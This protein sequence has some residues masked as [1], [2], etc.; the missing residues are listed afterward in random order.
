M[1]DKRTPDPRTGLSPGMTKPGMDKPGSKPDVQPTGMTGTS[2]LA[3]GNGAAAG[4]DQVSIRSRDEVEKDLNSLRERP[5]SHSDTTPAEARARAHTGDVSGT[6]T[7][8]RR[9]EVRAEEERLHEQRKRDERQRE[10]SQREESR[11]RERAEKA[12]ARSH[13]DDDGDKSSAELKR[14]VESERSE[15]TDILDALRD[16]MSPGQL[17][18]Q[19]FDYVRSSGGVDFSRNLGRSVRDNPLPVLMVGAGIAWLMASGNRERPGYGDHRGD[20]AR[21]HRSARD[22]GSDIAGAARSA[23]G[24][25]ADAASSAGQAAGDASHTMSDK[26]SSGYDDARARAGEMSDS[27][28]RYARDAS[29]RAGEYA[30][31]ARDSVYRGAEAAQRGWARMAED[32]PVVLGAIG[33]AIGAAIGAAL[34]ASRTENRYMGE[35]SDAVRGRVKETVGREYEHAKDVA[36]DAYEDVKDD[37]EERGFSANAAGDAVTSAVK[38]AGNAAD[39]VAED[40][41][42]DLR[43]QGTGSGGSGSNGA[44]GKSA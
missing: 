16:K 20:R 24:A 28:G 3:G 43:K 15:I 7:D 38:K 32:Q 22:M 11:R 12:S 5:G 21:D 30:H 40:A 26:A 2:T 27:V 25:V 17:V 44:A 41:K 42:S 9:R 29:D 39:K 19:A 36:G 13:D 8:E 1:I 35:A 10:E 23:T 6:P 4:A 31:D 33:L 14:E 18:D 34:P 37:L